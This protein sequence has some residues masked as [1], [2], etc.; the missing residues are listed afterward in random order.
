MRLYP[1][2]LASCFT[3]LKK[4]ET[5][6]IAKDDQARAVR[7]ALIFALAQLVNLY[8][9]KP[10]QDTALFFVPYSIFGLI[11]CAIF[12]PNKRYAKYVE[13]YQGNPHKTIYGILT[14]IYFLGTMIFY[15]Y[16][17]RS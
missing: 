4:I 10:T 17:H 9:I 16:T 13:A 3:F 8:S 12:I 2:L 6:F 15:Y 11:N 5:S 1:F 7:V 14:I